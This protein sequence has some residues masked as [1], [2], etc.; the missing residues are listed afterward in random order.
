MVPRPGRTELLEL[1]TE[2]LAHVDYAAGHGLEVPL[3]LCEELGV[4][5]DE[6]RDAGSVSGRV[7]NLRALE[8]GELGRYPGDGGLSIGRGSSDEVEAAGTLT[9]QAE[10]LCVRLGNAELKALLDKVS[11]RPAISRKIS[12]GE[13]LVGRVEEGKV[14]LRPDDLRD[15]LP[16]VLCGVDTR[17]VMSAGVEHDNAALVRILYRI[18]DTVKVETPRLLGKVRVC[19]VREADV[20]EDLEVVR[21]RGVGEVD[22]ALRLGVVELGEEEST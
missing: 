6:R 11:D 21:P 3:P 5:E 1:A 15:L 7:G 4:V 14:L 20:G 2:R 17:R 9:V 8:D 18:N 10:V 19:L 12:R 16:L 13:P 22:G